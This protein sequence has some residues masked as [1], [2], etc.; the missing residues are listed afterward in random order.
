[1]VFGQSHGLTSA[2]DFSSIFPITF[3]AIRRLGLSEPEW[4]PYLCSVLAL[5]SLMV[6]RLDS[7]P[8]VSSSPQLVIWY[9][10]AGPIAGAASGV[11]VQGDRQRGGGRSPGWQVQSKLALPGCKSWTWIFGWPFHGGEG[12]PKDCVPCPHQSQEGG[13]CWEGGS[14]PWCSPQSGTKAEGERQGRG[15][16]IKMKEEL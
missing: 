9:L 14:W 13:H 5:S 7:S 4:G 16:W 10:G 11:G 1:M 12:T 8:S 6:S 15:T 2:S 3:I